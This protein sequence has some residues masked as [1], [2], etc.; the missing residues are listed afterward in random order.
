M[1]NKNLRILNYMIAATVLF[2]VACLYHRL[3]DQI[4]TNWNINGIPGYSSRKTIWLISGML[5]LFAVLF[6]V[7]PHMD[8]RQDN[9]QKFDRFYDGFCVGI[10]LFLA[11]VTGIILRES[12]FPGRLHISRIIFLLLSVMFL[13]I[14]N[15][16]PKIQSNFYM[17]IKTPW[18]LSS[19]EVWRKTHRLGG[20]L[21]VGCGILTMLSAFLLPDR[22]TGIILVVLV[23]GSSI[24]VTFASWLWWRKETQSP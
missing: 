9:Y 12:F 4:P 24:I 17:G 10:Q 16:M 6:D 15:Y 21:Y 13:L 5:P 19:D 8:P 7:M 23:L 18:T 20:K 22:F 3:P 14:G 11:I 1:K 2:A